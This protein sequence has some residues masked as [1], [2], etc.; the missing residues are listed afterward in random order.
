MNSANSLPPYRIP[1]YIT[2]PRKI[3]Y[4]KTKMSYEKKVMNKP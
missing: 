4:E 3:S 2:S 1:N